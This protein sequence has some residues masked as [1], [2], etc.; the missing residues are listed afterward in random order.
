MVRASLRIDA[1]F[2]EAVPALAVEVTTI[3]DSD[4]WRTAG[5]VDKALAGL[6]EIVTR[7]RLGTFE[8]AV[9]G[10]ARLARLSPRLPLALRDMVRRGQHAFHPAEDDPFE[11]KAFC[12]S[13]GS[14]LGRTS[15]ARA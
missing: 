7:D 15:F 6:E 2:D 9:H 10:T 14:A 3:R 8:I 13:L 11:S 4:H 1:T 12:S 5:S